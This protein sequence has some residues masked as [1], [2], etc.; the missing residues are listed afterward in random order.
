LT[1]S[2]RRAI[3]GFITTH[4]LAPGATGEIVKALQHA[5]IANGY[6]VGTT[7]ADGVFGPNTMSGLQAFQ[8][9]AALPVQPFCDKACWAALY[10]AS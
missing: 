1:A 3:I 6:S 2:R 8:D 5:L 7:G 10:S 4:R 9:N